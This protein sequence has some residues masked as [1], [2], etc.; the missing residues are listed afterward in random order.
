MTLSAI[1]A[2]IVAIPQT[3]ISLAKIGVILDERLSEIKA[4]LDK[5]QED[6]IKAHFETLKTEMNIK[7]SQIANAKSDDER[8]RLIVEMSKTWGK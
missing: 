3:I 5:M 8:R 1:L 2:A 6:K 7:L 4:S